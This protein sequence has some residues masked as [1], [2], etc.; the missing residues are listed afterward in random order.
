MDRSLLLSWPHQPW[1]SLPSTRRCYSAKCEPNCVHVLTPFVDLS[2]GRQE[3]R[4]ATEQRRKV[5]VPGPT[6]LNR[7]PAE[8]QRRY[9]RSVDNQQTARGRRDTE[10]L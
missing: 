4:L 9:R 7:T 3:E 1:T 6:V 10:S 5:G 2:A 8:L